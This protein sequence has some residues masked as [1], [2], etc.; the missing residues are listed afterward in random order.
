L[1][2]AA[3]VFQK[4]VFDRNPQDMGRVSGVYADHLV[5]RYFDDKRIAGPQRLR[6]LGLVMSSLMVACSSALVDLKDDP[7]NSRKGVTWR[8]WVCRVTEIAQA[9]QLPTEVRKDTTK[10][11]DTDES[12][13]FKPSPFVALIREL[14]ALIPEAYR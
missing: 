2:K 10:S 13:R 12:G 14:Q 3:S 7:E 4:A 5:G 11:K 9:H 1:K 8:N 6:S